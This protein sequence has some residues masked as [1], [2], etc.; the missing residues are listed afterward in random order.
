MASERLKEFL[1]NGKLSLHLGDIAAMP[2]EDNTVDK[3]FHSN[4]Y[5]FWPDLRKGSAEIHRVMKP[6]RLLLF[7]FTQ[8]P[9]VTIVIEPDHKHLE[10]T[11]SLTGASLECIQGV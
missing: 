2:L 4:C 7:C 1:A 5:F 3:V 8:K 11:N 10:L 6:G 9:L